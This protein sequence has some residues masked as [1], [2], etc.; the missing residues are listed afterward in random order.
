M[1]LVMFLT[2]A[3]TFAALFGF[4]AACEKL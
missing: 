3:A 1:W 2:G 4:V